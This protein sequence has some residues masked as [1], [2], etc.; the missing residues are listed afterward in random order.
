MTEVQLTNFTVELFLRAIHAKCP[1][2]HS[3]SNN[4]MNASKLLF[5]VLGEMRGQSQMDLYLFHGE[6]TTY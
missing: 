5:S 4:W 1:C 3:P 6:F 2:C